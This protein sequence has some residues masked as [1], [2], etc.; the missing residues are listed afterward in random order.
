MGWSFGFGFGPLRYR[1]GLGGKR[2]RGAV[3]PTW[4]QIRD[5]E[6]KRRA[7]AASADIQRALLEVEYAILEHQK[8]T[9][10]ADTWA[11][12]LLTRLGW[13]LAYRCD[14]CGRNIEAGA[15]SHKCENIP[16]W[17]WD[18]NITTRL[19]EGERE[20]ATV[21]GRQGMYRVI[22]ITSKTVPEVRDTDMTDA[23]EAELDRVTAALQAYAN[24]S[25]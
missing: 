17:S 16:G 24:R 10:E 8:L 7:A 4:Q 20:I 15:K 23:E 22:G 18:E 9:R 2:R 25:A 13:H 19:M 6:Q 12:K 14:H 3:G 5:Q 21:A 11:F 1:K